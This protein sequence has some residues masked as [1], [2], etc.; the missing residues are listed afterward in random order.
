MNYRDEI[1]SRNISYILRR[2]HLLNDWELQFL[3]S[4][5]DQ[6]NDLSN[7]QFNRLQEITEKVKRKEIME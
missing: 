4:V 6:K 5:D 1:I 3:H 2:K 7:K